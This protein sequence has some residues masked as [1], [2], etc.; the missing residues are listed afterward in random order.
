MEVVKFSDLIEDM[1]E[2]EEEYDNSIKIHG[3]DVL[4]KNYLP[5]SEKINFVQNV[6]NSSAD[7]NNFPNLMKIDVCFAYEII[8]H[9]TN[10][11][12]TEEEQK[13]LTK[14]YDKLICSRIYSTICNAIPSGEF[15][16]IK[17]YTLTIIEEF[18]KQQNSAMG[19][20]EKVTSDYSNLDFE[21]NEI[22]DKLQAG[23]LNLLKEV[24]EKMG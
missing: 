15:E 6:L 24:L 17:N 8:T 7:D 14:L 22:R 20:M 21:A 18:Y 11:T 10:I 12:F 13:D 16:T 2:N 9:Y 23:D 3:K 1:V 5:M 19:I 4:I